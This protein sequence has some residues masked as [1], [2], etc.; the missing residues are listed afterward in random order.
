MT[1]ETNKTVVYRVD[2][3]TLTVFCPSVIAAGLVG[4]IS[5]EDRRLC[6][7]LAGGMASQ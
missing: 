1:T 2:N 3:Q 5:L 6:L 7:V 4:S